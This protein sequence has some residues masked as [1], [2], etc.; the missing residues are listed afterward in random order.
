MSTNQI[1]RIALNHFALYGYEG[2]S[3][4]QIAEEVGIKKPSIYA[5][6]KGK[7]DLF[8]NV[9]QYAISLEKERIL[10]HFQTQKQK[11]LERKL[12]CF[13]EWLEDEFHTSDV[14]KCILRVTYFPPLKLKDEVASLVDPFLDDMQR[15]L[16]RMFRLAHQTERLVIENPYAAALAYITIVEGSLLELIY[17][18]AQRYKK[19][20]AAT[21]P[22]FWKGVVTYE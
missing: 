12:K 5:H 6:F 21:W 10:H 14:T 16:T 3:L 17:G 2:A 4:Q 20:V 13:L 18:N 1:R 22:I 8:L 11:P 9:V 7:D 19:R 15:L